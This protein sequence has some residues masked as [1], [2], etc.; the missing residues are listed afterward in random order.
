MT[1]QLEVQFYQTKRSIFRAPE[2]RWRAIHKNGNI[3]ADSAE[4]YVNK[5]D[6][7]RAFV[8]VRTLLPTAKVKHHAPTYRSPRQWTPR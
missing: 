4:G 6:C 2:W 3:M 7:E 5:A 8:T 1:N